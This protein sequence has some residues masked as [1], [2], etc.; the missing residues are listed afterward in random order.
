MDHQDW[1]PVVWTKDRMYI[2]PVTL[3]ANAQNK[4][5]RLE[6]D[7]VCSDTKQSSTL[8]TTSLR[9]GRIAKGMSQQ[10][11][12]L[13]CDISTLSLKRYENG[14]QIPT[15]GIRVMLNRVLRTRLPKCGENLMR[16]IRSH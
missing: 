1:K 9:Q 7:N 6:D 14:T 15:V 16:D 13:K 4:Y 8:F 5:D 3:Q 11:L 10:R 2:K 12:A